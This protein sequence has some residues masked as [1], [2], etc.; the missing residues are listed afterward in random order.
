MDNEA[1]GILNKTLP[2]Q[3]I[4]YQLHPMHIH[5]R[6]ATERAIQTFKDHFI[7]GLC[8]TDPKCPAQYLERLLPQS[9]M[10][11]NMLSNS[12]TNPKLSAYDAIFGIYDFNR[13]PLLPS[14]TKLILY[15]STEGTYI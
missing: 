11:L 2:K 4:P 14:D 15:E 7:A 12:R 13:C 8:S 9:A 10:T 3:N 1:C 6:N 5:I